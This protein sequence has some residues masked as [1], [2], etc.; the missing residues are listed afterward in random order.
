MKLKLLHDFSD[1]YQ[2]GYVCEIDNVMCAPGRC[3]SGI[4]VR[5][6]NMGK[7]PQWFD[8]GWFVPVVEGGLTQRAV[9]RLVRP[10]KKNE[11]KSIN[12][13]AKVAGSPSRR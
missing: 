2:K 8:L 10:A 11:S 13:S 4:R 12:S 5:I 1:K 6:V 9:G 7:Q 3:A